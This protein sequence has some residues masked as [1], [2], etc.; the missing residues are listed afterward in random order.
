[1]LLLGQGKHLVDVSFPVTDG[2]DFHTRGC[3][4]QGLLEGL[5]PA[6]AFLLFDREQTQFLWSM[7]RLILGTDEEILRQQ[8]QGHP[9]RG[10][11]QGGMH[12]KADLI[13]PF[14]PDGTQAF[15]L[16]MMSEVQ[17]AGVLHGEHL[18]M[19]RHPLHRSL[20]MWGT[21]ALWCGFVVVEESIGC[22]G[23]SPIFT[24]LVDRT[25]GLHR[26]LR[27]QVNAAAIQTGVLEF[28]CGKFLKAPL[29]FG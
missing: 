17:K 24:S 16:R 2:D 7:G 10:E 19:L 6:V 26:K 13:L 25:I 27:S 29:V 3:Q 8:S 11:S 14:G 18:L 21:Y 15:G 9:L 22:F 1:L 20:V 4:G 28:D 23:I 5:Q 12:P